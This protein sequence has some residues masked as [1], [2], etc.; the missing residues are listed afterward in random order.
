MG[1][2]RADPSRTTG[3]ATRRPAFRKRLLFSIGLTLSV[4]VAVLG[5]VIWLSVYVWMTNSEHRRLE[6]EYELVATE[7]AVGDSIDVDAYTWTEPH[8]LYSDR[9]IDPYFLQAFDEDGALLRA[10]INIDFFDLE[11]YPDSLLSMTHPLGLFAPLPTFRI[12]ESL[13]HYTNGPVFGSSGK[14]VGYVQVAHWE[15]ES[16]ALVRL[17][18]VVG[19]VLSALLLAMFGLLKLTADRVTWPLEVITDS[20]RRIRPEDLHSRIDVPEEADRETASLAETLN[21]LLER[22]ENSFEST[23]AFTSNAAHE[24]QTPLSVLQAHVDLSLIK[25]R[26]QEEYR[27]TLLSLREELSNMTRTVGGLLS[28]ARLDSRARERPSEVVDFSAVAVSAVESFE[29]PAR[30]KGLSL[31]LNIDP[32]ASVFG[33]HGLLKDLVSNLVDNAIK[34]TESGHIDVSLRS[35][36]ALHVLEVSDT[37]IGMEPDE[38]SRITERFFRSARAASQAPGSGLGLAIVEQI[39]DWHGGEVRIRSSVGNGTTVRLEMP[40]A[41]RPGVSGLPA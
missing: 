31:R 24:L 14:I 8:H 40:S 10:S 12:G 41:G 23:R 35:G 27:G 9:R 25:S 26:S 11:G 32:Y 29:N 2:E 34:Y 17:G 1:P 19:L 5:V 6:I 7:I 3:P 33:E 18:A 36:E 39:V 37:G 30:D 38:V 16:G 20:T 13:L 15:P 22:L 21:A 28:L 4:T